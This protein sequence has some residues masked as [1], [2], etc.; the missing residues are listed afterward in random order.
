MSAKIAVITLGSK[1]NVII[2][3]L[4]ELR[5]THLD[6]VLMNMLDYTLP[7]KVRNSIS[8]DYYHELRHVLYQLGANEYVKISDSLTAL[9]KENDRLDL[10]DEEL[11]L[12]SHISQIN[13]NSKNLKSTYSILLD[14]TKRKN[15]TLHPLVNENPDLLLFK[16]KK[17]APLR[18]FAEKGELLIDEPPESDKKRKYS[19]K[20]YTIENIEHLK[21]IKFDDA[22]GEI[23]DSSDLTLILASDIVSLSILL[24]SKELKNQIKKTNTPLAFIWNLTEE[25]SENEIAILE[26]M[27]MGITLKDFASFLSETSDYVIIDKKFIDD[28][29]ILREEGCKVVVEDLF[30]EEERMTDESIKAILS[31]GK[32]TLNN[33][34][35]IKEQEEEVT[36]EDTENVNAKPISQLLESPEESGESIRKE[37]EIEEEVKEPEDTVEEEPEDTVEEEP[38]D[39]VE[40][41]PEEQDDAI[42]VDFEILDEEEW[43][44]SAMRAIDLA[45]ANPADPAF[46]WLNSESKDTEKEQQIAEAM[47]TKWLASRSITS[48][49][50]GAELISYLTVDHKIIY[51]QI[52]QKYMINYVKEMQEDKCRQLIVLYHILFEESDSFGLELIG[53]IVRDLASLPEDSGQVVLELAKI[54][55]LQLVIGRK[56]LAI[57]AI[58]EIL[59]VIDARQGSNA[60]LWNILTS[61]DASS[62]AIEMVTRFSTT[63]LEEITRKSSILRF[64]G[65]YYS[66]IS[67]VIQ[68]WKDGDKVVLSNVIGNAILPESTLRKFERMELARSVQ[69]L[70]MVQVHTLAE[71]LNKDVKKVEKLV[72]ELIVNGELQAEFKLIDEKM[73]LV[74]KED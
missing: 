26:T 67:K 21:S 36:A 46:T 47:V 39:T 15:I 6:F 58:A 50:T 22:I 49:K 41:E 12:V 34:S 8:Q 53:N 2:D 56:K 51:Q 16:G 55:I 71:T 3:K 38:E 10:S 69:K 32:I 30:D 27:E 68:A 18:Y 73:Y 60:E 59:Q 43:F 66:I 44:D 14:E 61:F 7:P 11:A 63:K 65:S 74:A 13:N 4:L 37:E 64:T 54:S 1:S 29:E 35:E 24:Q 52:L 42:N 25:L 28:V 62:V 5:D 17:Y 9:L 48:R 45:F 40:E 57:R 20:K 31:I 19:D 70:R 23:I 33:I 72:T